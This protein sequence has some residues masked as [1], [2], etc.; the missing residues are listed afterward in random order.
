[1]CTDVCMCVCGDMSVSIKHDQVKLSRG[2]KSKVNKVEIEMA[3][4]VYRVVKAYIVKRLHELSEERTSRVTDDD[5]VR[6]LAL[7]INKVERR[8]R[9]GKVKM[10]P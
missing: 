4:G 7:H 3:W 6:L 10:H 5:R 8:G 2:T 1:M 9:D